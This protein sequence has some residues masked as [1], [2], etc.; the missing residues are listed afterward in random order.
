MNA[1]HD[2]NG[3]Q[4]A[5]GAAAD[6][7][8]PA[9]PGMLAL[10]EVLDRSGAIVQQLPVWRWPVTVGR[11]LTND[12]VL[13]DPHV[14]AEH[15]RVEATSSPAGARLAVEVLDTVN[16]VRHGHRRQA[17]GSRFDWTDGD[18]ISLGRLRLRVRLAS[19][20]LAPEQVLTRLRWRPVAAT[21][22]LV[23]AFAALTT[24]QSWLGQTEPNQFAAGLRV[25][26]ACCSGPRC[27]GPGWPPC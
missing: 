17:R 2:M 18:D 13:A 1:P 16:G 26:S 24:W 20:A 12:L 19:A 23:L 25:R 15:L 10:I 6:P 27:C 9:G 4:A 8:T 22:G 5:D 7:A 14:A 21:L 11:A 3:E